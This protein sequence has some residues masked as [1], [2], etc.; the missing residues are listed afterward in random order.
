MNLFFSGSVAPMVL[1]ILN[2]HDSIDPLA[3]RPFFL[4][5]GLEFIQ[6]IESLVRRR[7][8]HFLI[9]APRRRTPR[10]FQARCEPQVWDVHLASYVHRLT[11]PSPNS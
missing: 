3:S 10:S 11:Q 7:I 5:K 4:A 1:D 8:F 6:S 9:F 2:W